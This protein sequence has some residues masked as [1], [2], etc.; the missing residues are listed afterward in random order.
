M[1]ILADEA[2]HFTSFLNI[3]SQWRHNDFILKI[4]FQIRNQSIKISLSGEFQLTI[5]S[6]SWDN[7]IWPKNNESFFDNRAKQKQQ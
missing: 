3:T 5:L 6:I 2:C 1:S 4:W 7:A